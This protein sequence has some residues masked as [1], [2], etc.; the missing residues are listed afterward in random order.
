MR[1]GKG[2]ATINLVAT[3]T[4]S[5]VSILISGFFPVLPETEESLKAVLWDR[6]GSLSAPLRGAQ[7]PGRYPEWSWGHQ[8]PRPTST[9]CGTLFLPESNP[10]VR[11]AALHRTHFLSTNDRATIQ[12][13]F[14]K[15]VDTY[16]FH[17][18]SPTAVSIGSVKHRNRSPGTQHF[19]SLR[20]VKGR[21]ENGSDWEL[22]HQK[23]QMSK[24]II[25][26]T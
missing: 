15:N 4:P 1:R 19:P 26:S 5:K 25:N 2:S 24:E 7:G 13:D 18:P 22:W 17:S 3:K 20:S 11:K 14:V 6:Q 12:M 21:E 10:S 8:T 23:G 9:T 16:S